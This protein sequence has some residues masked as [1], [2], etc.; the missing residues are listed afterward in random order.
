MHVALE[1]RQNPVVSIPKAE[2]KSQSTVD[3]NPQLVRASARCQIAIRIARDPAIF[4][5]CSFLAST[6]LLPERDEEEIRRGSP[7]FMGDWS[8]AL[9]SDQCACYSR[10]DLI[11]CL[12]GDY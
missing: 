2:M 11:D 7:V 12:F 6:V 10:D 9:D 4:R 8:L 5:A 3:A 1:A